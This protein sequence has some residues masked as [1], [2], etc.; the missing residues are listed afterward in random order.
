MKKSNRGEIFLSTK[1]KILELTLAIRTYR[2]KTIFLAKSFEVIA[3]FSQFIFSKKLA[4]FPDFLTQ[5]NFFD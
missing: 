5:A 3:N 4:T 2:A 1:L